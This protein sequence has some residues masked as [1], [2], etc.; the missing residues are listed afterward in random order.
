MTNNISSRR[1]ELPCLIPL[2]IEPSLRQIY[3]ELNGEELFVCNELHAAKG[4]RKLHIEI[5]SLGGGLQILHCVFFPDPCYDLPIFGTDVVIGP[6]GVSAAIVDLSPVDKSLPHLVKNELE[7]IAMP[8]FQNVRE[9]PVWGNIFSNYVHFIRPDRKEEEFIFLDLVDSY[10]KILINTM[11][12][13][14]PDGPLDPPTIRRFKGQQFYCLQQ[15]RNDKTRNVLAKVFSSQWADRYIE[16]L[17][18]DSPTSIKG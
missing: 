8:E 9:L 5:A 1:D 14:D 2:E 6:S 18:F 3:G 17:L 10:L 15:K 7:K 13:T 11:S 12:L 16:T 4:F